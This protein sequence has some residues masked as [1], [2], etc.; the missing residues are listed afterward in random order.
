MPS[1][2]DT[3]IVIP[4]L[5]QDPCHGDRTPAQCVIDSNLYSE[6]GLSV[7]ATQQQINNA[8]YLAFLNLKNQIEN[9]V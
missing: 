9:N 5:S 6:L 2:C 8:L 4:S 7:N 1:N 3:G